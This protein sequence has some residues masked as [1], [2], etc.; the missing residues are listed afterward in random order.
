M[1][2]GPRYLD[3]HLRI[4]LVYTQ[5]F[6]YTRHTHTH[7]PVYTR[8]ATVTHVYR[9]TVTG[10]LRC[11]RFAVTRVGSLLVTRVIAGTLLDYHVPVAGLQLPLP[12]ALDF[13]RSSH[14]G[15]VYRLVYGWFIYYVYTPVGP[16]RTVGLV[17]CGYT[18]RS[19]RLPHIYHVT[20]YGPDVYGCGYATQFA[21]PTATFTFTAVPALYAHCHGYARTRRGYARW[22]RALHTFTHDFGLLRGWTLPRFT[23]GSFG[24]FT[25]RSVC[26]VWLFPVYV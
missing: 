20:V 9:T 15:C 3:T 24:W 10:W 17:Y 23:H 6:V 25:A 2:F 8:V 21:R 26:C 14:Y 16:A 22:L 1:Q 11:P 13:A 5:L 18:H 12:H 7:T 4:A 19:L